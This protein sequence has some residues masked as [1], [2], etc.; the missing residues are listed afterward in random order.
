MMAERTRENRESPRHTCSKTANL[1]AEGENCGEE[2]YTTVRVIDHSRTGFRIASQ[3]PIDIS[4]L[5]TLSLCTNNKPQSFS[6]DI[7]WVVRN[8]GNYLAG[9][10]IV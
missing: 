2:K 7:V 4:D 6:A 10:H 9:L 5:F 1:T 8:R 3:S